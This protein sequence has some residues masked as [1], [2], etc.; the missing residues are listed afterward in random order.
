MENKRLETKVGLFVFIGL[1]LVAALLVQFSK[2]TS[3]FHGTYIVRMHASN[4]GGLLPRAQVLLSGVQV[5]SVEAI[6]LE[7]DGKS[8][9]IDLSIYKQYNQIHND[10]QFVI[11]QSG[12]LGDKYVAIEP[13]HNQ[14][15]I[16]TND[17]TVE[18]LPPFNL[19][20]V[21]QSAAG[22]IERIDD[23]ARKL[24]ES[25][26]QLQKAVLNEQTM[27]NL[28]LAINNM[29]DF[30]QNAVGAMYDIDT[31]VAT[32]RN[33]VSSAVSN[34]LFFSKQLTQ[35]A[36]SADI[37]LDTNGVQ[38]TSAMKNIESATETLTNL[39]NGMQS[40][41]GL[42]GTILQNPDL[43]SNVQA[44]AANLAMTSSNLNR[45][46]LWHVLWHHEEETSAPSRREPEEKRP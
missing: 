15:D 1:V 37:L 20:E 7:P 21:A 38:I 13:T 39:M 28:S 31:L 43:S 14:G 4:V 23:T 2:G 35:L 8:V 12:F 5:G 24:D 11:E 6:Q 19:Q 32:N 25:V 40:G 18:C 33:T 3:I 16:L 41:Q 10:A 42:A 26:S 9:T 36:G 27:T 29:R 44:I 34:M 22:F 17:A 45:Y 46:G 30:S